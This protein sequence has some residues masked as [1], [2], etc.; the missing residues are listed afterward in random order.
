MTISSREFEQLPI[1]R[2]HSI[3][4]TH[5]EGFGIVAELMKRKTRT[6][7]TVEQIENLMLI[8]SFNCENGTS[9]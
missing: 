6:P 4:F 9:R 2:E 8:V 1:D 3:L 7:L 5:Y